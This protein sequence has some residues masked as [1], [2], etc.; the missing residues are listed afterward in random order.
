MLVIAN[1]GGSI[2]SSRYLHTPLLPAVVHG[3][4]V[5]TGVVV[6][7]GS[8]VAVGTRVGVL[9]GDSDVVAVATGVLGAV[10]AVA[11]VVPTTAVP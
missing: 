2:A 3:V 4:A 7:V 1:T 10:V 8:G 11:V 5:G 9:V 6:A